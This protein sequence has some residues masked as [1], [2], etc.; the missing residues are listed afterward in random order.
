MPDRIKASVT[1]IFNRPL[2]DLRI[3]VTD[4]CNFRCRFCMP[5]DRVYQF[6]P[7]SEIL[8]FEEIARLARLFADCGVRKIRITGGEPLLRRDLEKLV[9]M[10]ANIDGVEE[11]A[12]T[13]NGTL[14]ADKARVLKAAGLNRVTISL[15]A[16]DDQLFGYLN[17]RGEGTH[18]VIQAID[19]AL[20]IGLS[21]VKLNTVVIRG[22]N[23]QRLID[24][25][26]FARE[27]G[28]IIRFIEYMDVG[29]LNGWDPATVVPA[30]EIVETITRVWPADPILSDNPHEVARRFRYR[31]RDLEFGVIASVTQPFCRTCS[32]IRLSADGRVYTCLFASY[33]HDL[34]TILRAGATDD[35]IR[36]RILSIWRR[37]MDRYSEERAVMVKDA[38]IH[39]R[40]A[41]VEMFHI[42]G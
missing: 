16:L 21:P 15:H 41:R 1:D 20:E 24:L 34:K 7:R 6:L 33:G 35:R 36:E 32:R 9:A 26:A 42:G 31:D 25:A 28:V 27:R 19:T 40:R 3:S 12:L 23:D 18:R 13:T 8:T 2:R 39:P 14:L 38:S 5:P 10:L 17:G 30:R 37:R 29:T 11:L 22:V 4:R